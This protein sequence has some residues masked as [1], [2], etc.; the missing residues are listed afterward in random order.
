M[1]SR[2]FQK[3]REDKGLVYEIDSHLSTYNET[4][5]FSIYAGLNP[6]CLMEVS[7]LINLEIDNFKKNLIT[8]NELFKS[9]EQLKGN[10]ILGMEGTFN[11]MFEIGKSMSLLNRIETPLEVLN[12]ID[13]VKMDDIER[14]IRKVFNKENL[15]ISYVGKIKNPLALEERLR[16]IFEMRWKDES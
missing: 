9:K 3:I 5:I 7:E 4:G 15:N 12:K 10:Y 6:E 8:D 13:N 14:V 11:R 16:N 2:L 1:S